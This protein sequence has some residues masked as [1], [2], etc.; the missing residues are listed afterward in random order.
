ML[1]AAPCAA[2]TETDL[3]RAR[4]LFNEALADQ[5]AGRIDVALDEFKRVAAVRDTSQVEYRIG[6]C[7]EALG[8]KRP[9]L[10]AYDRSARL[11]RGESQASDVVASANERIG[12]LAA[13]MGKLALDVHAPQPVTELSVRVDG[14]P[15]D[16]E[17]VRSD[18]VL[19]PG[20]HAVDVSAASMKPSHA[21]VVVEPARRVVLAIELS[22]ETPPPPP[23]PPPVSYTRRNVGIAFLAAGGAVGIG[24][25]I[26]LIVRES[27]IGTI[28]SD[29]PNDVCPL[30]LHDSVESMRSTATALMPLAVALG[31]VAFV[32]AGI[33][34][35]LVALGPT[36]VTVGGTF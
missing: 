1:A 7:L 24:A 13:T 31:A 11:G 34:G 28:Q 35:L 26:T 10:L 29:C 6:T 3:E 5:Q 16:A 21:N 17:E 32:A 36:H 25:G 23:P 2:T 8:R 9:A 20:T 30:A 12:A 18:V 4:T 19:E 15:I 22:P 33:G 14:E 27:L